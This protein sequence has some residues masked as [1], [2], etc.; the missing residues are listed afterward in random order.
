MY[1]T[2]F[3]VIMKKYRIHANSAIGRVRSFAHPKRITGCWK[4]TDGEE[5]KIILEKRR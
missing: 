2:V 3:H 4:V 5:G 1:K